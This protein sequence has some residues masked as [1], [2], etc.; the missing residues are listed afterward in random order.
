M[1]GINGF[2]SMNE[3]NRNGLIHLMNKALHH[4]GPDSSGF[5]EDK[6]VC[7][8]HTRLSI[9][10]LTTFANQ[11]F[12]DEG[13]ALVYNGEVYNYEELAE[14]YAFNCKTSSDT[15]VVFK[16]LKKFGVQFLEELN[17]MFAFA[18]YN[19]RTKKIILGRDRLGIKPL[20]LFKNKDYFAFSS[21]LKAL[22][23]VKAEL[24]GFTKNLNS[25]NSFLHLGYIPKPL[26]I[27]NEVQKFPPGSYGVFKNGKL[28]IQQFWSPNEKIKE[29]VLTDELIAKNELKDLLSSSIEYR[30]KSDVPFGTFLSGGID[31]STV[32]AIA[33]NVSQQQIKTFSIGFNNPKFNEADFARNVAEHIGSDHHEFMV[34]ENDAKELVGDMIKYYDEPFGDSSAIPTMLVSKLARQE[35]TMT[36]SGDGGDELFHGYG[37]YNCSHSEQAESSFVT[38][39]HISRRSLKK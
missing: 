19:K 9:L 36:L 29:E 21:E 34:T 10:D 16:G 25:I 1:C 20:Y 27:Y 22:K 7:L 35:V 23:S 31:S 4:R 2:Y 33:Q 6:N 26:T 38:H 13:F 3:S 15:E 17:G 39:V 24:G 14:K 12:E 37:F 11:P 32:S 30:L 8:G 5:F 18:F 28:D